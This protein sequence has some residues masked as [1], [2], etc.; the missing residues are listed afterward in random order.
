MNCQL[1]VQMAA[2]TT[3]LLTLPKVKTAKIG[4]IFTFGER[5]DMASHYAIYTGNG[6]V[7]EVE[8]WGEQ[9]R[10]IPLEDVVSE[11][12]GPDSILR[13][14]ED[15]YTRNLETLGGKSPETKVTQTDTAAFKNWFGDSKIVDENGKPKVMYHGTARDITAFRAKQAGA[16]FLTDDPRFAESFTDSSENYMAQEILD[17]LSKSERDALT[18]KA[19][20]IAKKNG[21]FSG[22]EMLQLLKDRLPSGGNILP[23]FV[24]AENPFDFQNESHAIDVFKYVRNKGLSESGLAAGWLNDIKNGNWGQIEHPSVQQAIRALGFD[25]FYV[26]EGGRKNL[27]VYEP[28]QIKSAIGN[29]GTFD[30]ANP[31][32]RYQLA[33]NVEQTLSSMTGPQKQAFQNMVA[34]SGPAPGLQ[35]FTTAEDRIRTRL[36]DKAATIFSDL[37]RA[38]DRG[39]LTELE[40]Q[41]TKVT[42][43]QAEAAD[44]LLP[45]FFRIGAII[46]DRILGGYKVEAQEGIRPPVEVFERVKAWGQRNGITDFNKAWDYSAK[47]VE[48]ARQKKFRDEN[49]AGN[50]PFPVSMTDTEI[51]TLYAAYQADTDLQDIKKIL[52]DVRIRLIRQMV[53]VG[54][55]TPEE[56]ALWEAASEYVPFDRLSMLNEQIR[57]QKS[58]GVGLASLGKLPTL[59]QQVW[60]RP[61]GNVWENYFGTLGWMTEEVVRT[62]ALNTTLKQL[63]KIGQARFLGFDG[64]NAH[65]KEAVVEAY[66]G[67]RKTYWELPNKYHAFAFNAKIPMLP[68]YMQILGKISRAL[69]TSITAIPTFT[70]SQLPQDIQRGIIHS[71]VKDTLAL[72]RE[73][74]SNFKIFAKLA[75]QGK[76]PEAAAKFGVRGIYGDVDFRSNE[77]AK[78]LL[79]QFGYESPTLLKSKKLG[80]LLTRLNDIARASDL[81]LRK[82][83]YDRTMAETQNELLALQRAREIINFRTA[84]VGDSLG[85]MSTM[86]QTIP[87]FNAYLQGTDVTYRSIVGKDAVSGEKRSVALKMFYTRVGWLMAFSTFYALTMSGEDEYEKTNLDERDRSW[88]IGKDMS[89]PAPSEIAILFKAIPERVVEYFMKKGTPDEV[90]GM[91]AI[92]SWHKAMLK[93]Y[94]GRLNPIPSAVRPPLE[95]WANRSFRTFRELEGR[96]LQGLDP[97]Q[98]YVEGT[99]ELAKSGLGKAISKFAEDV[100]GLEVSPII[101]DN[102]LNGYFGTTAA[103]GLMVSNALLN[104]DRTDTPLSKIV[105]LTPFTIPEVGT[106]TDSE[107]YDLAKKVQRT[108]NT[109]NR[110][111][112]SDPDAATRYADSNEE[113]LLAY[114]SVNATL[115]YVEK[116]RAYKNF[117]NSAEGAKQ[118]PDPEERRR[119]INQAE[120]ERTEY[121]KWVRQARKD[122]NI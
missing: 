119:L 47:L 10:E 67:G 117:L 52:D 45:S 74:L 89:I 34:N 120:K 97:D 101:I 87:F 7:V 103:L 57:K 6:K 35:D 22:D 23:L 2:G 94:F 95:A 4:D 113:L 83:I 56:G 106:R 70:A 116:I 88:I 20:A 53:D 28:T 58:I 107:F 68:Q 15:A 99:S 29:I 49:L 36:A 72:T 5:K 73:V 66:W 14:N 59:V 42:F 31:D 46:K 92:T 19:K 75:A 41:R 33:P 76:L 111:V 114:K 118:V 62:D 122:L 38:V 48:S 43:K 12:G 71:G 100:L 3:K 104:P 102:T 96:Y 50:G 85:I 17:A 37:S 91:T 77:P 69:R 63:R 25:S 64:G 81:A 27:A 21:T 108:K 90:A 18:A 16:I 54:R 86:L 121:V 44:Q 65:N 110:L 109:L 51:A 11:Y 84:G 55:L 80:T 79:E 82:G 8:E 60:A 26:K 39:A 9:A 13:P 32:I 24:R 30:P 105:G 1:C 115:E 112:N 78:S 61:V 98:R 40:S 93:E